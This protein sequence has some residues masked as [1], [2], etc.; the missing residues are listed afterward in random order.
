MIEQPYIFGTGSI[1]LVENDFKVSVFWNIR[2][3]Y[4]GADTHTKRIRLVEWG[5]K[6][7]LDLGLEKYF[8]PKITVFS[9]SQE[10]MKELVTFVHTFAGLQIAGCLWPLGG[11]ALVVSCCSAFSRPICAHKGQE[12]SQQLNHLKWQSTVQGRSGPGSDGLF[13]P[14][15][16]VDTS[17]RLQAKNC[18]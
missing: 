9:N 3:T 8:Y 13:Q 2:V 12:M 4:P 17:D 6:S 7:T 16:I 11:S 5:G 1:D 18:S 14:A 10:L 15:G